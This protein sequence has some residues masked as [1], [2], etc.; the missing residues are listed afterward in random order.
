MDAGDI[1]GLPAA[2]KGGSGLQLPGTFLL[3]QESRNK[4]QI[5]KDTLREGGW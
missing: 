1:L 3:F 2:V 5:G 4:G